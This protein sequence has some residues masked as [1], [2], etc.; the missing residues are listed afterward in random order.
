MP[1]GLKA[2]WGRMSYGYGI[3]EFPGLVRTLAYDSSFRSSS[4]QPYSRSTFDSG[5]PDVVGGLDPTANKSKDLTKRRTFVGVRDDNRDEHSE[6]VIFY[7]STAA[8]QSWA[9]SVLSGFGAGSKMM[10]D[11]GTTTGLIVN[12]TIYIA[13]GYAIPHAFVI[14]SGK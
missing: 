3:N 11:G 5:I 13:P 4:I 9:V 14:Y 8:P 1:F 6:T 7:S 10:L 12:S 2:G